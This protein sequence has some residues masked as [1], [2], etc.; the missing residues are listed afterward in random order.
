KRIELVA[1]RPEAQTEIKNPFWSKEPLA[2]G[3][4][5]ASNQ[6]AAFHPRLQFQKDLPVMP[7]FAIRLKKRRRELCYVANPEQMECE[8]VMS[9]F[10]R[11]SGRQD[12]IRMPR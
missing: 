11:T 8:I 1:V 5:D 6:R 10:E 3:A 9:A 4:L 12:E 2:D 7:R